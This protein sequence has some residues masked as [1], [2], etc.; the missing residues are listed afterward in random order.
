VEVAP[1]SGGVSFEFTP[2]SKPALP[3]SEDLLKEPKKLD[4]MK[5]GAELVITCRSGGPALCRVLLR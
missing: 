2:K 3:V 5:E 1:T 4:V